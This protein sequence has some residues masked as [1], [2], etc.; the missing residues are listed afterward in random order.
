MSPDLKYRTS[1]ATGWTRI[2][3]L[4][5]IYRAAIQ[6]IEEGLATLGESDRRR[7][8]EAG[9]APRDQHHSHTARLVSWGPPVGPGVRQDGTSVATEGP[10]AN[11]RR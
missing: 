5:A 8:S 7:V 9:T 11:G 2:D 10:V 1:I 3:M 6:S 4:L